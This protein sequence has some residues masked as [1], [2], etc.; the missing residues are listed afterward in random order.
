MFAKLMVLL[1]LY[2]S[3]H[4]FIFVSF[5]LAIF[6]VE[7]ITSTHSSLQ[8]HAFYLHIDK[9]LSNLP[10]YFTNLCAVHAAVVF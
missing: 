10:D 7:Y 9:F 6:E 8:L 4:T 2:S 5:R 3:I 1:K